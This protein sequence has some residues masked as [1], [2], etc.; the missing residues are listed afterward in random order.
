MKSTIT[1]SLLVVLATVGIASAQVPQTMSYQGVLKDDT[2]V[3]VPDGDYEFTFRIYDAPSLGTALWTEVQTKHVTAG[4]LNVIL[5]EVTPIALAFDE[6]YWLGVTI[7]TGDELS[8][9]TELTG[10]PYALNAQAVL[11]THNEFPDSG[12][13]GIGT[14]DPD[15][16]LHIVSDELR[17]LRID[18]T[19]PGS[20]SLL[21]INASGSAL[22]PGIEFLRGDVYK[23]RTN[24]DSSDDWHFVMGTTEVLKFDGGT[25]NVGVGIAEPLEKLDIDGAFKLGSTVNTNSGTIRWTGS[26]FEGYDGGA[27]QSFTACGPGGELP[28]GSLGQTLRH[29]GSNW[30]PTDFLYNNGDRIGIGTTSPSAELEVIGDNM[31]NHFKL[32]APTGAGPSLYFNALNKDWTIYGSN[33][34][35]SA[36]DRKLVFRDFSSAEDRMVI[37][38][39]GHVGIGEKYPDATLHVAGGNFSLDSSEGDFKIGD[40]TYSLKLGVS[41]AGDSA[42][43]HRIY[44]DGGYGRILIGGGWAE[45]IMTLYPSLTPGYKGYVDI[46]NLNQTGELSVWR[47]GLSWAGITLKSNDY[48]GS[49]VLYDDQ[50]VGSAWLRAD[51]DGTGVI[52]ELNRGLF[53]HGFSYYGNVGGSELPIVYISGDGRWITFDMTVTGDSCVSL[54]PDVIASHEILDEPGIA[55]S[56]GGVS[57]VTLDGSLQTLLYRSIVVPANGYV[58]VI[59]TGQAFISHIMGISRLADFGVSDTS[60]SLPANQDVGLQLPDIAASGVY[61]FPVTVHGLFEVNAGTHTFYSLAR[62]YSGDFV[63]HDMQLT[64]TYIPTAYGTVVSTLAGPRGATDTDAPKMTSIMDANVEAERYESERLNRDRID[65]ELNKLQ[66]EIERLKV[67]L[68]KESG[69]PESHERRRK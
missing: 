28:I 18:G 6:P 24:L 43:Y 42:G 26:D 17:G 32:T 7:G 56:S 14:T 64:L 21:S 16:P 52:L 5:G 40:D 58:Q 25:F 30:I 12:F 49:F 10:A 34:G 35:S 39:D 13:V 61:S 45:N 11:G 68:D 37:D 69:E 47:D 1:I 19:R 54:P 22:S 4:I 8:P 29:N 46:G 38:E 15:Y 63:V 20:W 53:E 44:A 66:K 36:G 2:G 41:T 9:R 65:R 59:A 60:V 33:P 23:A 31:T 57:G 3:I 62:E 50:G 27:W 55:S 51:D 67:I 48:G